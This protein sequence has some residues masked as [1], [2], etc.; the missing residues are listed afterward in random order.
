LSR[1]THKK[2]D[3]LPSLSLRHEVNVVHNNERPARLQRCEDGFASEVIVAAR[4]EAKA[5]EAAADDAEEVSEAA[6]ASGAAVGDVARRPYGHV[7]FVAL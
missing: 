5:E 1:G 3:D 6:D 7:D 2:C 4:S